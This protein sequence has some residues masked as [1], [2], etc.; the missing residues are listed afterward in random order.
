MKTLLFIS[1]HRATPSQRA[2]AAAQ[3]YSLLESED[4]DAFAPL[5]DLNRRMDAIKAD[6][7]FGVVV[8]HPVIALVA[9]LAGLAVGVFQNANRAAVGETPRFEAVSLLVFPQRRFPQAKSDV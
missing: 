9:H 4:L 1:R 7:H 6:G 3:E 2:L 5:A 8:V